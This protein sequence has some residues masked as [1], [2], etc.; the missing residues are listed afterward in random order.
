MAWTYAASGGECDPKGFN[1][2]IFRPRYLV[3]VEGAKVPKAATM[4][5][6]F[7]WPFGMCPADRRLL[8]AALAAGLYRPLQFLLVARNRSSAPAYRRRTSARVAID[9]LRE[10]RGGLSGISANTPAR[11]R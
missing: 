7:H 3:D 6:R 1:A 2:A 5:A 4:L 8:A 10:R 9:K 11:E